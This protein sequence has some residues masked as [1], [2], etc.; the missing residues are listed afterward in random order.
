[1]NTSAHS[2]R[3]P[4]IFVG[5]GSPMNAIE[6]NPYRRTWQAVGNAFGV[7]WLK[8]RLILCVSAHWHTQGWWLTG[9]E[10][11]TTIH[12]FGGFPKALFEQQYPAPGAPHWAAQTAELLRQPHNGEAV[13]VDLNEW[14]LDHGAWCVLKP[15]FPAADIPVVQLSIDDHRP[16]AEHFALGQ[17][18]RVLR[19]QGVLIV[20]SGNTVHNLRT[21]NRSAADD[22][23]YEWA[24]EFDQWV[25]EQIMS[26]RPEALV[27]FQTQGESA[28]LSHPSDDHFLPLLYAAG[29][30]EAGEPVEFFNEGY[31]LASIAMR[32]VIWG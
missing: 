16:P 2:H 22:Q 4:V 13:G 12:D 30:A 17:Q 14:G 24:I 28:K 19:E 25:A 31:Q 5:H 10:K 26:G 18:L 6:D 23:A 9:M 21:L 20:S 3:M 29:A 27:D 32:S 7:R 15:M 11:P 8:P 1:M